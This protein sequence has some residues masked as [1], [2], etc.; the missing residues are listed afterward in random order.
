MT[1]FEGTD[2]FHLCDQFVEFQRNIFH[3]DPEQNYSHVIPP[4]QLRIQAY[5][6]YYCQRSIGLRCDS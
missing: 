2:M 5:T 1:I 3:D 6:A 4:C